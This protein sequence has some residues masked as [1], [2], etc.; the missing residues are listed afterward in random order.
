[1]EENSIQQHKVMQLL[2]AWR[3][4]DRDAFMQLTPIIYRELH[5]LAVRYMRRERVGHTLQATALVNEAFTRLVRGPLSVN[6]TKHFLAVAARLMRNILVDHSKSRGRLKRN[7]DV[8]LLPD[9]DSSAATSEVDL[10]ILDTA[11]AKF[12]ALHEGMAHVVELTYFGGL[13]IEETAHA[14]DI[15]T[16]TVTRDLR[17]AKAWLLNEIQPN[18]G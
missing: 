5:L 18:D 13:T 1:M 10:I 2:E 17:F 12:E 6:D 8:T 3:G 14:L 7:K 11:L 9:L 15:S 16:A 4:G